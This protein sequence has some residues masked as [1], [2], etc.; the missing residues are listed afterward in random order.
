MKICLWRRVAIAAVALC[1]AAVLFHAQLAAALITRGDDALRRGDRVTAIAFYRRA[2]LFDAR[3]TVAADRLAFYLDLR[4]TA[5][6]A[7]AAVD[8]ATDALAVHTMDAAL[9]ADRGLAEQFLRRF[10]AAQ[11][12]FERAA[13]SGNDPRYDHFAARIAL[14]RGRPNEARRLF[15]RALSRDRSFDPARVAL[16]QLQ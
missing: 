9:L 12:D 8:I 3:S 16:A 6:D 15:K 13:Q 1:L 2:L 7:R 14:D 5:D 4:R 10:P 11:N